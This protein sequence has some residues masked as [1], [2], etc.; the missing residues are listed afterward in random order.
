MKTKLLVSVSVFVLAAGPAWAQVS[1]GFAAIS[2][3]VRDASG[4]V[5]PD[6]Q[7]VID[8]DS[9]GVHITLNTSDGGVF[10]A[11]SLVPA[12]GYTVSVTKQGFAKYEVKDGTHRRLEPEPGGS[13]GGRR[14]RDT[15]RRGGHCSAGE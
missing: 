13:A 7:V 15:G 12:A 8:N 10:N 11:T 3:T 9:K 14:Y 4:A 2:G 1:G 6:A 5:V